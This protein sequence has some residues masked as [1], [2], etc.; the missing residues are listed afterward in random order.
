MKGPVQVKESFA[1][2]AT[3]CPLTQSVA[4]KTT[5]ENDN[6][7]KEGLVHDDI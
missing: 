2:H 1:V 3:L 4:H 7:C 6:N 5:N